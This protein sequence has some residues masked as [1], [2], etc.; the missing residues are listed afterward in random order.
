MRL[1]G[2]HSNGLT[3]DTFI[4]KILD[5]LYE[6]DT[7]CAQIIKATLEDRGYYSRRV[8]NILSDGT[9][10]ELYIE[11]DNVDGCGKVRFVRTGGETDEVLCYNLQDGYDASSSEEEKDPVVE[12]CMHELF[13]IMQIVEAL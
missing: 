11:F 12:R 2:V 9:M 4:N 8:A 10:I 5:K 3:N 13:N 1:D 6:N 7:S